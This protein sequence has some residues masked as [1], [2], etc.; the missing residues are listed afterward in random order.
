MPCAASPPSRAPSNQPWSSGSGGWTTPPGRCSAR[1]AQLCS[2][3]SSRAAHQP[4]PACS[5]EGVETQGHKP[6]RDYAQHNA[7]EGLA[8]QEREGTAE[9]LDLGRVVMEACLHDEPSDGQKG[10]TAG[11]T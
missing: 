3:D 11:E 9:A 7:S 1:E 2:C 8:Q 6:Q 5:G 10:H 4:D